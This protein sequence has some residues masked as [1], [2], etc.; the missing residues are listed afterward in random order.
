MVN[1]GVM[2]AL[3]SRADREN[4]PAHAAAPGIPHA[5]IMRWTGPVGMKHMVA[6]PTVGPTETG[7][8]WED[9]KEATVAEQA[10]SGE[11]AAQGD[12]QSRQPERMGAAHRHPS[13]GTE[14]SSQRPKG[15]AA[16]DS[17]R[18]RT[19]KGRRLQ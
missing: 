14:R 1:S 18:A 10:G 16:Q 3:R 13:H 2:R 8:G 19:Q 11:P 12:R 6:W 15:F 9:Q 5:T 17:R 4:A 7:R